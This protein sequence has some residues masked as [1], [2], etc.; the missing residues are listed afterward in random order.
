MLDHA[1]SLLP[2]C[3]T[4]VYCVCSLERAEGE[5]QITAFLSRHK[6]AKRMAIT[7]AELGGMKELVTP[8]GDMRCLPSV[9]ADKGGMDGFFAARIVKD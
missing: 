7:A 1:F 6:N 4:L 9:M 2:I 8:D 5:D 3:G